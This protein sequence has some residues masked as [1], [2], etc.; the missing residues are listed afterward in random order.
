MDYEDAYAISTHVDDVNRQK[1]EK[2]ETNTAFMIAQFHSTFP[3]VSWDALQKQNSKI[4]TNDASIHFMD[5]NTKQIYS[6]NYHSNSWKIY[7]DMYK[8]SI[9]EKLFTSEDTCKEE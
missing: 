5:V 4:M 9:C 8:S 1:K 7:S 6:W 2:E 3:N